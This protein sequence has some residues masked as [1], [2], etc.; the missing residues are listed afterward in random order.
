MKE[1]YT[2]AEFQEIM[3]RLRLEDGCP[4]DKAQTHSSLKPALIRELTEVIA[5]I[6]LYEETQNAENLC[7]ELG[8]L[9]M[10]VLLQSQIGSDNGSFT[11]H[12]VIDSASKKMIRRHPHVFGEGYRD[13]NGELV[14]AWDE[15][16][17]YEK[18]GYSEKKLQ[19][20]KAAERA[21]GREVEA[22]LNAENEAEI[23]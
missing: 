21:A 9:F 13:E 6:N 7:E 3:R 18:A 5:G 19:Q 15:I 22:F 4:W 2:F 10:L 11:I 23:P 16:K 12:D 20:Q 14:R 1:H 8:D 17:R